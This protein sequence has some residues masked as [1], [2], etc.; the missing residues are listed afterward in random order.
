MSYFFEE[1]QVGE[2]IH[3]QFRGGEE[4]NYHYCKI[5]FI[6]LDVTKK[7]NILTREED[8]GTQLN[9][10]D[11]EM[12]IL[13]DRI[14]E[15]ERAID[16]QKDIL[17]DLFRSYSADQPEEDSSFFFSGAELNSFLFAKEANAQTSDRINVTLSNLE[18]LKQSVSEEYAMVQA[19]KSEADTLKLQLL[20]RNSYL[21]STK[22]NKVAL[23]EQTKLEEKK[24]TNPSFFL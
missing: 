19:K 14:A 15:K 22:D 6:I 5:D 8:N 1:L 4:Q 21:A 16:E 10:L 17:L 23:L 24:Y 7:G 3:I 9:T 2:I 20:E 12:N 11:G 13:A 18:A